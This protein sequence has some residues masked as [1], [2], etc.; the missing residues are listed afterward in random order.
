MLGQEIISKDISLQKGL[1]TLQIETNYLASGAY[2][3]SFIDEMGKRH[4]HKLIKN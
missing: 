4:I 3:I 1:N 2:T